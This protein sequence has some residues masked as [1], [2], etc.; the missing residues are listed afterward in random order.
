MRDERQRERKQNSRPIIIIIIII[1]IFDEATT[2]PFCQP[3]QHTPPRAPARVSCRRNNKNTH[4]FC[5]RAFAVASSSCTP[6][7]HF[8]LRPPLLGPCAVVTSATL[9]AR[10]C[11]FVPPSAGR[12]VHGRVVVAFSEKRPRVF[13]THT[14]IM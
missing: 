6:T 1:T 10:A 3:Q 5:A 9:C 13:D 14:H 2:L 11:N 4:S 7:T 8:P 12:G